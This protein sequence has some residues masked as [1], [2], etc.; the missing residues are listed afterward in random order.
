VGKK[1]DPRRRKK[2]FKIVLTADDEIRIVIERAGKEVLEFAVQS[3]RLCSG[4][5]LARIEGRWQAIVRFET[6]HGRPHMEISHPAGTEETGDLRF[7]SYSMAPTYA[8]RNMQERWEFYRER[9]ERW[10]HG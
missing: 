9:F 5:D 1:A 8:I 2:T 4:Q 10:Q 3:L 7:E 6:A